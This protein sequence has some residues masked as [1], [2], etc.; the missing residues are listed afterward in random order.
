MTVYIYVKLWIQKILRCVLWHLPDPLSRNSTSYY[1]PFGFFDSFEFC[2]DKGIWQM[3]SKG[4][5]CNS[6][7]IFFFFVCM[8]IHQ[9]Q[10]R[11]TALLFVPVCV[12]FCGL[13]RTCTSSTRNRWYFE[14]SE[15]NSIFCSFQTKVIFVLKCVP[16][17]QRFNHVYALVY[18]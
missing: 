8:C 13:S 5:V 9:L 10:W 16:M 4:I 6:T 7:R 2:L 11:M 1:I 18:F 3:R 12:V 15:L 14:I 17:L